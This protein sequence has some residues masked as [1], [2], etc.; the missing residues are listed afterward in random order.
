[1]GCAAVEAAHEEFA[2]AFLE[3][4]RQ[5]Q[6]IGMGIYPDPLRYVP[7][8]DGVVLEA[9][10][11]FEPNVFA[12]PIDRACTRHPVLEQSRLGLEEVH[13]PSRVAKQR[14]LAFPQAQA[15]RSS[16]ECDGQAML[17]YLPAEA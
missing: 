9:R 10:V 11:G 3:A 8:N 14:E 5:G 12:R 17:A 7:G 16:V 4:R 6:T 1:M 15:E 2:P 13:R